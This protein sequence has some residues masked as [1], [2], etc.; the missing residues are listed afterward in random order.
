MKKDGKKEDLIV[1]SKNCKGYSIW[2]KWVDQD[3][4]FRFFIVDSRQNIIY[5]SEAYFYDFNAIKE[6][7]A[8]IDRLVIGSDI[9]PLI[10]ENQNNWRRLHGV[11]MRR[12]AVFR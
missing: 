12:R 11:P 9:H 6:G 3:W 4:G 2:V 8:Y 5:K 10:L 7:M 1:I